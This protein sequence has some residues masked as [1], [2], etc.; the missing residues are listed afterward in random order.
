MAVTLIGI[1]I[2]RC[3]CMQS[4]RQITIL[5]SRGC[6]FCGTTKS[7]ASCSATDQEDDHDK[8]LTFHY[9]T[10]DQITARAQLRNAEIKFSKLLFFP[11]FNTIVINNIHYTCIKIKDNPYNNKT[12]PIIFLNRQLRL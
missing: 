2:K 6:A 9:A 11:V 3:T 4:A 1:E 10:C 5:A 12:V 7:V 8:V